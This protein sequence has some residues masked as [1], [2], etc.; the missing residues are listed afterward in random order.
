[1]AVNNKAN[2]IIEDLMALNGDLN[3]AYI[4]EWL[5]RLLKTSAIK[6]FLDLAENNYVW[7]ELAELGKFKVVAL[8][9][10]Y[11][12]N[13]SLPN[14]V[15]LLDG[16]WRTEKNIDVFGYFKKFL[17]DVFNPEF[18][19]IENFEACIYSHDKEI[20]HIIVITTLVTCMMIFH[21]H[22]SE[23]SLEQLFEGMDDMDDDTRTVL[24][25]EFKLIIDLY[26][27]IEEDF[28]D[29]S[30]IREPAQT[31]VNTA[32]RGRGL[33]SVAEQHIAKKVEELQKTI[34]TL[35]TENE[36]FKEKNGSLSKE[37]NDKTKIIEEQEFKIKQLN[38]SRED[39]LEKLKNKKFEMIN[40]EIK[41]KQKEID[42]LKETITNIETKY[43]KRLREAEE[44]KDEL[45]K[46]LH[47]MENYKIE[48]ESLRRVTESQK[49]EYREAPSDDDVQRLKDQIT[50]LQ[51]NSLEDKQK[52][53]NLEMHVSE[54][55]MQAQRLRIDNQDLNYRVK[56]LENDKSLG[57]SEIYIDDYEAIKKEL[58][59]EKHYKKL[60][61]EISGFNDTD[62]TGDILNQID[63]YGD[64]KITPFE[65]T[66]I[67]D[68]NNK[69]YNQKRVEQLF[70]D[71][72][73]KCLH[74]V[75]MI[76]KESREYKDKLSE[77]LQELEELKEYNEELEEK[78]TNL[79][80]KAVESIVINSKELKDLVYNV[81][82]TER[83]SSEI[84]Q[85][86]LKNIVRKDLE[87]ARLR[88]NRK[89]H[90]RETLDIEASYTDKLALLYEVIEGYISNS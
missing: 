50:K 34:D 31:I 79:E 86:L 75:K 56:E 69:E 7:L 81:K 25:E 48:F 49:R 67:P 64:Q 24:K 11:F 26:D 55:S 59:A 35:M 62:I 57:T 33:T 87:I 82:N 40:E 4:C 46:K 8:E 36:E 5:T 52:C 89:R 44:T 23:D 71:Y 2:P 66:N 84:A 54:I 20:I 30:I 45:A 12:S 32:N 63:K 58:S 41:D 88:N 17:S 22:F 15:K 60:D 78:I 28:V 61:D 19:F 39:I 37:L 90:Q 13:K 72:E 6:N 10:P 16:I 70:T 85:D 42:D 80:T 73:K 47:Q 18:A 29:E 77:T 53:L 51:Q 76:L 74:R 65:N 9:A 43:Q 68:T 38:F 83:D 27:A 3:E 14:Y 1:M 21:T